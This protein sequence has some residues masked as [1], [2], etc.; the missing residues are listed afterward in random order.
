MMQSLV[1]LCTSG[2]LLRMIVMYTLRSG[3]RQNFSVWDL[4]EHRCDGLIIICAMLLQHFIAVLFK[5]P[6]LLHSMG[7]GIAFLGLFTRQNAKKHPWVLAAIPK[8][9]NY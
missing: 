1:L 5:M 8:V 7:G 9:L 4:N 3:Q 2:F 6:W